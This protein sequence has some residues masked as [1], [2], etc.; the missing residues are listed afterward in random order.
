[1]ILKDYANAEN[2]QKKTERIK[3]DFEEE[4]NKRKMKI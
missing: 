2:E 3:K 1:M 4:K